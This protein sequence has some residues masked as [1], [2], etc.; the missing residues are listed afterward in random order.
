MMLCTDG[1]FVL[2]NHSFSFYSLYRH[3]SGEASLSKAEVQPWPK[4]IV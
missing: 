3:L 1:R 2:R 4:G